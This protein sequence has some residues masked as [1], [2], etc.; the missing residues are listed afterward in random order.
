MPFV[1]HDLFEHD[2]AIIGRVIVKGYHD[3]QYF[4]TILA[5]AFVQYC[6]FGK[7]DEKVMLTSFKGYLS[8]S[9]TELIEQALNPATDEEFFVSDEFLEFL[10]LF[11]C[12]SRVTKLNVA[13]VI[14]EIAQQ[15]LIQKPHIMASAWQK[16]FI[17]LRSLDEFSSAE[18]ITLIYENTYPTAKKVIAL[19]QF[20]CRDDNERDSIAFLKRYIK[21]LESTLLKK[22]LKFCTGSDIIIVTKLEVSFVYMESEFCR[23]PVAHT[24]GPLLELPS[25][26]RNFPELRSE[27]TNILKSSDWE[28]DIV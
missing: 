2:W 21:G 22:F 20:D 8:T 10:E 16:E 9:E 6:F 11:K 28:M 13:N 4:P 5:I 25:T 14:F 23:R 7:V 12:R 27:F 26:Y 17:S 19:L 3:L 1:R 18:S 15:E 24:C